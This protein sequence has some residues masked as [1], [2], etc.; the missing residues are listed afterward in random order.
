M[1]RG[2]R[3]YQDVGI[4]VLAAHGTGRDAPLLLDALGTALAEE[5]WDLA[6]VPADGLGRLRSRAAIPLLLKPGNR[7][8]APSCAPTCSA[9]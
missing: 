7:A 8:R 3:S 2:G 6:A 1:D 4:D 5:D 9:R